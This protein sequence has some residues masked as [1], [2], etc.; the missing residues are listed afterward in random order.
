MSRHDD[1]RTMGRHD[2]ERAYGPH[3]AREVFGP[4]CESCG[5]DLPE[6]SDADD[7]MC[8]KCVADEAWAAL[9]DAIERDKLKGNGL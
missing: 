5:E 1:A 6:G 3:A 8:A 9:A 2:Y 4:Y 7:S